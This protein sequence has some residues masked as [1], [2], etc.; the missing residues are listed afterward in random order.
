MGLLFII[1]L[2]CSVAALAVTSSQQEKLI[3]ATWNVD[4]D[5]QKAVQEKFRC[6]GSHDYPS[7]GTNCSVSFG[8][9]LV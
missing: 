1:L 5:Q 7:N 2:A 9:V 3:E 4:V 6:C 8:L